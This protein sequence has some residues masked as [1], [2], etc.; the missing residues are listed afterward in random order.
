MTLPGLV[1]YSG[2]F[3]FIQVSVGD[4]H[5]CGLLVNG[6][7]MCWGSNVDGQLGVGNAVDR[8]VP[9]YTAMPES[10]SFTQIDLGKAHS[11][12]TTSSGELFCWGSNSFGQLGDGTINNRLS[13]TM[14]TL[15]TG[16]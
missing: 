1:T 4:T 3:G 14:A 13:P 8:F 16:F 15:P 7:S 10:A 11:C 5:T 12:A 9:A 6:T 2:E